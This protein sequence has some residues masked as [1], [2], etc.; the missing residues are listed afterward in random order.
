MPRFS[1]L[2]FGQVL[3][4]I[5]EARSWYQDVL[6]I[7]TSGTRLELIEN[8]TSELLAELN[9]AAAP[10]ELV[11]RWSNT[12]TYY[13]LSDGA[14]FGKIC[15]EIRRV[16]PNLLPRRT[17]RTILEGPLSPRDENPGDAT[18]NA[19]NSFAE[20]ELAAD[21]SE[22][23]VVP[24]GFDDLQ[25]RFRGV[26]YEVQC[27]RLMSPNRVGDNIER[28]YQQLQ[29]RMASDYDRGLIVLTAERILGLDGRILRVERDTDLTSE[30]HRLIEEFRTTFGSPWWDFVDTRVVG[31]VIVLR[32]LC[33]TVR[34]NVFGPAYYVSVMNLA[35]PEVFQAS[36]LERLRDL[37]SHLQESATATTVLL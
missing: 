16:G 26:N 32:F 27:K 35:S 11:E 10:E 7:S 33:Y 15:R 34:H 21:F 1:L 3:T 19:R 22:K 25:F 2:P 13:T 12:D 37:V 4:G 28:A 18:V 6:G 5:R 8:K 30:V 20:L 9:S 14:G 24:T 36:E 17:L 31:L 29:R 23:G